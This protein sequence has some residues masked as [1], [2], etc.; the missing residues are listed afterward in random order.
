M[1]RIFIAALAALTLSLIVPALASAQYQV[2]YVYPTSQPMP[3]P[4]LTGLEDHPL[5]FGANWAPDS[6]LEDDFVDYTAWTTIENDYRLRAGAYSDAVYY[7]QSGLI[8]TTYSGPTVDGV[9]WQARIVR[10]I[11]PASGRNGHYCVY[12]G[13]VNGPVQAS[14]LNVF[15]QTFVHCDS[16]IPSSEGR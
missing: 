8:G 15:T 6:P 12:D 10:Y 2:P 1:Q 4:P 3:L 16:Y 14:G 11:P 13:Y 9:N 7:G 5:G